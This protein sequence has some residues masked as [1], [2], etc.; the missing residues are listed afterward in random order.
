L[1]HLKFSNIITPCRR[2]WKS[3]KELGAELRFVERFKFSAMAT[4]SGCE[5]LS[6]DGLKGLV[7]CISIW[8]DFH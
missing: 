3:G 5:G 7:L 1:L 2:P 6:A 4:W 8:C